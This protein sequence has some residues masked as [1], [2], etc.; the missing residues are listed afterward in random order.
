MRMCSLETSDLSKLR[1]VTEINFQES[2]LYIQESKLMRL[3]LC[4]YPYVPPQKTSSV[5]LSVST[6]GTFNT[7]I[8]YSCSIFI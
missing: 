2:L 1:K 8:K 3:S 6:S 4:S 5:L 7:S